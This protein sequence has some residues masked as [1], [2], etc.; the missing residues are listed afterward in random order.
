M[1]HVSRPPDPRVRDPEVRR[2]PRR[3][4][5]LRPARRELVD[6]KVRLLREP[7]ASQTRQALVR[8]G[9]LPRAA[10]AF[11]AWSRLDRGY[12]EAFTCRKLLALARM[13][14]HATTIAGVWVD[15]ARAA[16]GRARVLRADVGQRRVRRAWAESDALAQ[17]SVS[18]NRRR[19]TLRGLHY[20]AA[21]H[22]EAK[23]VRCTAGRDLRRRRRPA[24]GR[25][26]RS[27]SWF[28]V[29]LSAENRLALYVPE[30][31]AHG[32]L[33]LADDSEVAYQISQPYVPEAG[34]GVRWDDPAFGIEWPGDVVV[35]NERDRAYPDFVRRGR[36]RDRSLRL[37]EAGE[38]MHALADRALSRSAAASP[39]TAYASTLREL[40]RSAS[41]SRST[42]CRAG[43]QVLDWIVPDEWNIRDA[44]VA[45]ADGERVVDFRDVESPRREL[46][47]ARTSRDAACTSCEPHLHTHSDEPRL[48]PVSHVVLLTRTGASASRERQ[49]DGSATAITR[50]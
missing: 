14:F 29:E 8:R 38:R 7:F 35:I 34:R 21:P 6:E 11:A 37:R 40:E 28:G 43:P 50:S 30:G 48:D 2:R 17:C 45:T 41:R 12:A 10:C 9:A 25:R 33:T 5:R 16:R 4:E 42:R 32:F 49:L 1:E 47:R 3:A 20:Q 18:F 19:G 23:L 46:Q 22:E 27:A 24:A 26:R 39:A 15:R 36:C 44:Y 13:I 31:C